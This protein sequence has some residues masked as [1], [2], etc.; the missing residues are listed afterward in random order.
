MDNIRKAFAELMTDESLYKLWIN[1]TQLL[2]KLGITK[3]EVNRI[4]YKMA[5]ILESFF[6]LYAILN[7]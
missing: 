3:A 6:I 7:K 1:A 4:F 5:P 2:T